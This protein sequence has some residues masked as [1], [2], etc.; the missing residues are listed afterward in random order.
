MILLV[1]AALLLAGF[2]GWKV[3]QAPSPPPPVVTIPVAPPVDTAK[4]DE[5]MK[6]NLALKDIDGLIDREEFIDAAKLWLE[7]TALSP[8][9]AARHRTRVVPRL[10]ARFAEVTTRRFIQRLDSLPPAATARMPR[11]W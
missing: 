6:A 3:M 2:L 4:A 11:P 8:D 1:S 5:I 7:T 9:F 10:T